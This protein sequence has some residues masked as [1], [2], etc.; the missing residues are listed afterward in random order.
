M[1]KF[2]SKL[3][4]Y[5]IGIG[6]LSLIPN[7]DGELFMPLWVSLPLLAVSLFAEWRMR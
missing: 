1:T 4:F 6:L 3:P 5:G 2:L 7:L